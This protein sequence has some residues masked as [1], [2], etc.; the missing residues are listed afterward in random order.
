MMYYTATR[1]MLSKPVYKYFNSIEELNSY[2]GIYTV[3]EDYNC[4][5]TFEHNRKTYLLGYEED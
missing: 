5:Y 3:K 1:T 2:Y 4:G